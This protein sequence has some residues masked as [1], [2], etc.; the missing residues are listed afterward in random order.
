MRHILNL[1]SPFDSAKAAS[2]LARAQELGWTVEFREA[3]RT[4]PQNKRFWELLGRVASRMELNG[5]KFDAESWK[6][7]F[8]T[9]MGHEMQFLPM[10]EKPGF[11]P[12]GFRSSKLTVGEMADLQTFIES[13]CAEKGVDIWG[14]E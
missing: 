4:D 14:T 7:I 11:F 2:Y 8:L 13:W 5:Q 6:C 3:K 10:L 12:V 1:S 9:A